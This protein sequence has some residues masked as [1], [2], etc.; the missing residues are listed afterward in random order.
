MEVRSRLRKWKSNANLI[1]SA[2]VIKRRIRIARR[3]WKS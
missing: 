1:N 2:N 3:L